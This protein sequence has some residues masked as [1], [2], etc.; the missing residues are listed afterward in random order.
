M[1]SLE[2]SD[3]KGLKRPLGSKPPLIV[4]VGPT[5]VGKTEISIQLAERLDGEIVSAD[6]RL[7]YRGMDIGTAKPTP[8]Q[9]ARLPHHLIDVADPDQTWSL[10]VFQRAATEA[11]ADI[12][13]RGRLPLLVGGT[14]QYVHTMTHGWAP[15][16]AA[17]HPRLRAELEDMAKSHGKDWLHERLAL[18]DSTAAEI[19]DPRNL[20]RTVRALEV[21]FTTGRKFSEQRGQADSPYRLLT[22]G[23]T[24][25]RPELYARIDA[26]IEAM[27]AAGLLDEVRDL[28]AIGYSPELPAM[29]SIGY[30]ECAAVLEGRMTLEQARV[31][32]RRLT[33][34]FVRRQAN[35]FKLEDPQIHW[36]EAGQVKTEAI[37]TEIRALLSIE[38]SVRPCYTN[39]S[40]E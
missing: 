31:Q 6:S 32:M 3:P 37:E 17:P 39:S 35:W 7:F 4:I 15:P 8:E 5:A 29:S 2:S 16:A 14:G 13:V 22:I 33:R 27:F 28:L 26:R 23:L 30:R 40:E 24:R 38:R 18:L 25:P 19:I 21:I 12:R 1:S 11:I 34:V 36:F 10:A 20:R 9:R